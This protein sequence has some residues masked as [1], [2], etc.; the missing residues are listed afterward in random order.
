MSNN[1]CYGILGQIL[2][3]SSGQAFGTFL[4]ERLFKPLGLRNTDVSQ[5]AD[6]DHKNKALPYM[7]AD[8][9]P[10]LVLEPPIEVGGIYEGAVGVKSSVSDL[11]IYYKAFMEAANDQEATEEVQVMA[12]HLRRF[13]LS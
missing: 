11:L 4:R 2:E 8:N 3:R 7:W 6:A 1:W 9:G 5:D 10:R 12:C 13:L